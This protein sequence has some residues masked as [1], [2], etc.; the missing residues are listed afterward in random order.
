MKQAN[1][2][3]ASCILKHGLITIVN[4]R[5]LENR[6]DPLHEEAFQNGEEYSGILMP[7]I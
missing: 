2:K 6:T 1:S 7:G 5:A 4:N 3:R